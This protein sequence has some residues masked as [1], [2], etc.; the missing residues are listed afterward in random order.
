MLG[1]I[2]VPH[3]SGPD[4]FHQIGVKDYVASLICFDFHAEFF[5]TPCPRQRGTG[6][7]AP[8]HSLKYIRFCNR[9][10]RRVLQING[11][12][13]Y[14]R[15]RGEAAIVSYQGS[16]QMVRRRGNDGIR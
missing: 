14:F 8:G 10:S 15:Y 3:A 4:V 5:S 13:F 9:Q 11:A 16:V 7:Q 1:D 6:G 2:D 12:D